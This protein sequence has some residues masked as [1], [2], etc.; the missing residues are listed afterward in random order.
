[1]AAAADSAP[2]RRRSASTLRK[3]VVNLLIALLAIGVTL[4]G[5]EIVA[6]LTLP[7]AQIVKVENLSAVAPQPGDK[8]ALQ[9]DTGIGP[10]MDWSGHRGVRLRKNVHAVIAAH[11][12]SGQDVILETNSIG[13]RYDE[14]G[15]KQADEFR[16]LVL[17]D[18]ITFEDFLN[19]DDTY[20][21][22]M[23]RLV[24]GRSQRIRFIN[25]GLPGV[26]T[27]EEFYLFMEIRDVVQPDLVLVAMYLN[28]CQ[29]AAA[30]HARSLPYPYA[31]SRLLQW[32]AER[33]NVV[34]AALWQDAHPGAIDPLWREQFRAGRDLHA[35]GM[36][37]K[38][39]GFDFEIY[40]AYTDFGLAWNP[41]CWQ[42]IDEE[43]AVLQRA[44]RDS[45]ADFAITLF[46]V[47]MQ[48]LGTVEDYRPQESFKAV[49]RRR[50]M[51]CHDLVP[52]LRAK[53]SRELFYDHCHH[54]QKGYEVVAADLVKWLDDERL[55][56]AR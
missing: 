52:A 29:N 54:R 23:E 1:M 46:P 45:G 7:P 2:E 15:P 32:A 11:H 9:G 28:D 47:A 55:I 5:L 51:R 43:V 10:V 53:P 3:L 20:T 27:M 48:V 37:Q 50:R 26:G 34:K 41:Q 6:R 49:C 14:L 4:T 56:P 25:A 36:L 39:D 12:V 22:Q 35:G 24:A 8:V 13:L 31:Y 44:V 38:R 40:H 33:F 21:R 30:F 19:E 17:G 18:S 42:I 16:V